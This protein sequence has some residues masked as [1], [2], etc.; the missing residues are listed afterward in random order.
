MQQKNRWLLLSSLIT[1]AYSFHMEQRLPRWIRR[2]THP[3]TQH[4]LYILLYTFPMRHHLYNCSTYYSSSSNYYYLLYCATILP[5]IAAAFTVISPVTSKYTVLLVP[6]DFATSAAVTVT[7]TEFGNF[8]YSS[9]YQQE[10]SIQQF[11]SFYICNICLFFGF[12]GNKVSIYHPFGL[13]W[14]ILWAGWFT[15]NDPYWTV[16]IILS[17]FF[18]NFSSKLRRGLQRMGYKLIATHTK[19]VAIKNWKTK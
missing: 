10:I 18:I 5:A 11:T 3:K 1:A 19:S 8:L 7:T 2:E 17:S 9:H 14:F 13:F 15:R 16:G 6:V 4:L 12:W